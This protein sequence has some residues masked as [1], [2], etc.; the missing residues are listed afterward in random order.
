MRPAAIVSLLL[1]LFTF[2]LSAISSCQKEVSNNSAPANAE[3]STAATVKAPTPANP[4]FN[5]EVILRGEGKRF[6]HVKFRQPNDIDRIVTLG[7]WV[8]DLEPNHEYKL[9]R[10]VDTNIDGDCTGTSWLTLGL[11]L[12]P[13]S[14]RTNE[15]GTGNQELWRSL[16]AFPAGSTFDIHF[17]VIDAVTSAVIL[18]S[19]CYKFTIR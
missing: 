3:I 14:I 10:A 17:R 4:P 7:V 11:G 19:D 5:L 1:C 18:T 6:G 13:Q 15:T 12:T 8:R 9:Q 2:I 16:A